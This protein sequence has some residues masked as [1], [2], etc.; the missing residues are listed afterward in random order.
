[1]NACGSGSDDSAVDPS[2]SVVSLPGAMRQIDFDDIVYS[3]RLSRVL[4]PR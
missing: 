3:E 4:V 1:M 2:A